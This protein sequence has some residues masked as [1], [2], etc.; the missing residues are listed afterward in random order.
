[1]N[2]DYSEP[3][4][5]KR[6]KTADLIY[7]GRTATPSERCSNTNDNSDTDSVAEL[8][9]KM[10]DDACTQEFRNTL[11]NALPALIQNRPT[12][13]IR[14]YETDDNSDTDSVA[15]LEYKAGEDAACEWK[16]RSAPANIPPGLIQN[17]P[18]DIIRMYQTVDNSD[19]DSAAEWEY[20]YWEDACA[21]KYQNTLTNIPPGLVQNPPTDIMRT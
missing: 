12:D 10:W 21:W 6:M 15:E 13:I 7:T 4:V 19:T 11:G 17:P 18:T 9:Y 5:W 14:N 20:K 8:E 3:D 16:C 2:T 1:M